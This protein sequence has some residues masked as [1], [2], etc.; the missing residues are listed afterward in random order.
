MRTRHEHYWSDPQIL[1]G[2]ER[3][4][5]WSTMT[6]DRSYYR[7]YQELTERQLPLIRLAKKR[8]A[9]GPPAD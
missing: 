5:I 1:E 6:E 9:E 4:R 8:G 3:Q 2:D 7:D